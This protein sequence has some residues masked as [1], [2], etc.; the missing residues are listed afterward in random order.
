M[1]ATGRN[2]DP[3]PEPLPMLA[4]CRQLAPGA[5]LG[6]LRLGWQDLR[7]APRQSLGYG[8]IMLLA[9]WGV[10]LLTWYW[11]NLGLYLGVV[12]GFVFLGPWLALTL[13]AISL[14]LQRG[15]PVSLRASLRDARQ[16][17]GG[18]MVFALVLVVL[19]LL[20]AR[21][22]TVIHVF[23][24][25]GEAPQLADLAWF[26]GVGSAVGAVFS[27]LVFA[28]SAFSLPML[29]EREVD[30]IT[31]V[32]SSVNAVLRNKRAMLVWVMLIGI[33]LLLGVVTGWL[34]F[35]VLLPLLGHATWHG[36]QQTLDASPWPCSPV[37]AQ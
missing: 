25:T 34:A 1:S 17:I 8:L 22:A 35:V 30:T 13:Y 23:F 6:W 10:S 29:L 28:V 16:Q 15:L 20:W 33:C 2:P 21:A 26:L 36:Y 3:A 11:G 31:A 5:A 18:A 7:R 37:A 32:V 4:E 27:A 24:P 19:F 14:R 9:S 12:S